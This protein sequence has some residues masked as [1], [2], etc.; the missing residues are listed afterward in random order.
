MTTTNKKANI[1]EIDEFIF[2]LNTFNWNCVIF[3]ANTYAYKVSSTSSN[4]NSSNELIMSRAKEKKTRNKTCSF[5][6][7]VDQTESCS[8]SVA[9]IFPYQ[10]IFIEASHR[11]AARVQSVFVLSL[12]LAL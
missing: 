2:S 11:L 7:R 8:F 6:R 5:Y 1:L 9:N 12:L 10:I 3:I 4:N